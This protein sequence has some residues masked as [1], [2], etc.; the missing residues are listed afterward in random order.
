[1]KPNT[2]NS[3]SPGNI[4]K[5]TTR[6]EHHESD[7]KTIDLRKRGSTRELLRGDDS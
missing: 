1:M 2:T 5:G 7:F 3:G 4:V 6:T